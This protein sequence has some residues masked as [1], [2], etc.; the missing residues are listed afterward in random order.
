[1]AHNYI[2]QIYAVE[3]VIL[4]HRVDRH[5]AKNDDIALMQLVFE[6]IYADFVTGKACRPAKAVEIGVWNFMRIS[7]DNPTDDW[8]GVRHLDDI[9]HV[10]CRARVENDVYNAVRALWL[11][12]KDTRLKSSRIE[13]DRLARFK[14]D[15][16]MRMTRLE[17]V[18]KRDKPLDIITLARD[19]VTAAEVNPL[20]LWE[21]FAELLLETCKDFLKFVKPLLAETMEMKPVDAQLFRVPTPH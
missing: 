19:V 14:I 15:D 4:D 8:R 5:I 6:R 16:K 9:R 7:A 3:G 2:W 21:K 17:V 10:A 13:R 12:F 18:Q 1:M 20:H 11:Y